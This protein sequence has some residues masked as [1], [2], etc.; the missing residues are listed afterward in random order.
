MWTCRANQIMKNI[1]F[2]ILLFLALNTIGQI[3]FVGLSSN[4]QLQAKTKKVTNRN[5]TLNDTLSLPFIDDFAYDSNY[6]SASHWLDNKK[7]FINNNFADNPPSVGV[8]TF[9]ILDES[10][11]MYTNASPTNF[12]ADTLTSKFINLSSFT[13]EDSIYMSFYY[14]PQGKGWDSPDANDSLV[15]QFYNNTKG[16]HNVWSQSGT[17]LQAFLQV[18]LPVVE[19]SYFINNFQFRF[20]NYASIGSLEN[21]EDAISNDF[22]NIDFVVLDTAR[23]IN[24]PTHEDVSF[25]TTNNS[26]FE[27]YYAVP[28]HHFNYTQMQKDSVSF[29]LN[30]FDKNELTANEITIQIFINETNPIDNFG[31]GNIN[32]PAGSDISFI[33]SLEQIAD[34]DNSVVHIPNTLDD[35]T[36]LN[37]I[38]FFTP[39]FAQSD[40]SYNYNDTV[41][42]SQNFYNYYAYDDGTAELGLALIE[43]GNKFAFRI[44]PLKKDSLRGLSMFFNRYHDYGTADPS[45]FTLCV[46]ANDNGLPGDTLYYE[47][48]INPKYGNAINRFSTY[49][50]KNAIWVK[51]TIFVGFINDSNKGYSVG[52]D[53]NN[54]NN[55]QVFV[56]SGENWQAIERGVPMIRAIFGD[57]FIPISV[58][59]IDHLKHLKIFP[60]PSTGAVNIE[61]GTDETFYLRVFNSTGQELINKNFT[62]RE[63]IQLNNYGAGLYIVRI[64][65]QNQFI[66]KK[67]I[68]L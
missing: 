39:N 53:D 68:I 47:E 48:G 67:I 11:L 20:Y 27:H 57:D 21:Q 26:L 18:M 32:I 38:K 55:H 28:W 66:N 8:A 17:P 31:F 9:D 13:A 14:Q 62:Q 19:T 1:S 10:G 49:K 52:Y 45:L 16:W 15:L 34:E 42:F 23:S 36:R 33:N 50:F 35:S 61:T 43:S 58:S 51:D 7:V 2:L 63:L 24:E 6:P 30:N 56:Q 37:L 5:I 25:K 29:T 44:D 22:W 65:N 4:A 3:Q 59:E 46:W 40:H 60:N 41:R 54:K 64:Q 12:T